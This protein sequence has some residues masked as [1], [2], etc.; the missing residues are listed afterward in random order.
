MVT[1]TQDKT[2]KL[3]AHLFIR[4]S[5]KYGLM[6]DA[7]LQSKEPTCFTEANKDPRWRQAMLDEFITRLQNET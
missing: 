4:N 3:K 7:K 6:G 2:R 1:R 5:L